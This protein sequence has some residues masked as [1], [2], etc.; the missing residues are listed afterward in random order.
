MQR[1]LRCLLRVPILA[2]EVKDFRLEILGSRSL[3]IITL[4]AVQAEGTVAAAREQG[5]FQK[6][7]GN[8]DRGQGRVAVV[9]RAMLAAYP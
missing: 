5:G 3:G 8:L 4:R 2:Q 6:G 7:V 9:Q 1:P